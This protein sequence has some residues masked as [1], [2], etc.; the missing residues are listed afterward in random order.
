MA[1]T[2]DHYILKQLD[3]IIGAE[4]TLLLIQ[5][6]Q[7]YAIQQLKA[8]HRLVQQNN[9]AALSHAAHRLKGESLQVGALQLGD[10]C[11]ALETQAKTAEISEITI[12][13]TQLEEEMQR[14][15]QALAQVTRHD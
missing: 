4:A 11:Q 5:Q 10:L 6:F 3:E 12:C 7:Q 1:I 9:R 8:F 13:L 15:R 14:V 2:L